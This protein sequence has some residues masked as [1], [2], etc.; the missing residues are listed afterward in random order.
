LDSFLVKVFQQQIL[1]QCECALQSL[2][3]LNEALAVS[4]DENHDPTAIFVSLQNLLNAAA[5]IAKAF[6]GQGGK[7]SD[8]RTKLRDSIELDDDSPL[9]SVTMR[10]NFEHFDERLDS[11]WAKSQRHIYVDLNI[12]PPHGFFS[13]VDASDI[14]RLY[15]PEQQLLVFWGETYD[16][17]AIATEIERV[18]L[19][20]LDF[21]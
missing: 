12:G 20:L 15:D 14:F 19:L 9:R 17:Q 10:N 1:F 7:L 5:N 4:A 16:V 21:G 2:S 3:D 18:R 6:W 8:Q 11:W 13:G